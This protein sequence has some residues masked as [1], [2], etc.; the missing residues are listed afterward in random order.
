M[1]FTAETL[2]AA[3]HADICGA[4]YR[5]CKEHPFVP[6]A[7]HKKVPYK[8]VLVAAEGTVQLSKLRGPGTVFKVGDLPEGLSLNFIV[9]SGGSVETHFTIGG[10]GQEQQGTFATLCNEALK[11]SGHAAP[12]P[13]YPR[14]ICESSTELAAAFRKLQELAVGLFGAL[15]GIG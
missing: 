1:N 5:L 9:Q 13:P 8:D 10:M 2:N 7:N 15:R 6:G 11:H 3:N 4:Y 12:N 14:P